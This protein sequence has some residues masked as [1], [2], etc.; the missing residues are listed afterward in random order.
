M[1]VDSTDSIQG[2]AGAKNGNNLL[3]QVPIQSVTQDYTP[4]RVNQQQVQPNAVKSR[5]LTET[6]ITANPVSDA[7]GS[8]IRLSATLDA[9]Q[10]ADFDFYVNNEAG[11]TLFG[12]PDVAVYIGSIS[13]DNLWPSNGYG[14]VTLPVSV[15]NNWGLTDNRNVVTSVFVGNNSGSIVTVFVVLRWRLI[16][17]QSLGNA[18]GGQ[19][20]NTDQGVGKGGGS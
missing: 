6:I 14:M 18:T 8:G 1:I 9:L 5:L 3:N 15:F 17:N 2:S 16:L 13:S 7:L 19:N 20:S 4:G 10:T 11:L 12:S